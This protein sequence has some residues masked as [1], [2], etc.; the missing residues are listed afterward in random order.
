[1]NEKNLQAT[2]KQLVA[3][4]DPLTRV[5]PN[6]QTAEETTLDIGLILYFATFQ[7]AGFLGANRHV[8]NNPKITRRQKDIFIKRH[9]A[10]MESGMKEFL[11]RWLQWVEWEPPRSG[12]KGR[13]SSK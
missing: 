7:T 9:Q 13:A 5:K 12:K 3:L 1:M 8:Q 2:A 11:V 10:F 6:G 4:I